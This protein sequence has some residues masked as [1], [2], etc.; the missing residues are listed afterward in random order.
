MKCSIALLLLLV[1]SYCSSGE[2]PYGRDIIEPQKT[3]A[4]ESDWKV[5]VNTESG[6]YHCPGARWYGN[7]KTG[8]YMTE[9][10]AQEAGYR[11]AYGKACGAVANVAPKSPHVYQPQAGDSLAEAVRITS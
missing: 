1:I 4:G 9:A 7:T 8:E 2:T 5:W 10:A 6:I 11:P 3:G